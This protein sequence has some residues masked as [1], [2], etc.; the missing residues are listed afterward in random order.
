MVVTRDFYK[1]VAPH[2]FAIGQAVFRPKNTAF[3]EVVPTCEQL[4]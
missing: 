2:L 3:G 1:K 4:T